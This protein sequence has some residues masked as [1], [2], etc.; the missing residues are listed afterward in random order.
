MTSVLPGVDSCVARYSVLFNFSQPLYGAPFIRHPDPVGDESPGAAGAG[1]MWHVYRMYVGDAVLFSSSLQ[2]RLE[3]GSVQNELT[4]YPPSQAEG[5]YGHTVF[6]Y[7]FPPA[8]APARDRTLRDGDDEADA[9]SPLPQCL[10]DGAWQLQAGDGEWR[11]CCLDGM[12][13]LDTVDVGEG[14][15]EEAH[16][17]AVTT[18]VG[19]VERGALGGVFVFL[20]GVESG[21]EP[22]ETEVPC[23]VGI[24]WK[25]ERRVITDSEGG[26]RRQGWRGGAGESWRG[27]EV[28]VCDDGE[29]LVL[30]ATIMHART[31]VCTHTHARTHTHT[32]THTHECMQACTCVCTHA[33]ARTLALSLS[34][35][36]KHG[37]GDSRPPV[38]ATMHAR[39]LHRG[40][41]DVHQQDVLLPQHMCTRARIGGGPRRRGGDVKRRVAGDDGGRSHWELPTGESSVDRVLAV[42]AE[43]SGAV[44][45]DGGPGGG[46]EDGGVSQ[47]RCLL[48]CGE[49]CGASARV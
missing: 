27:C 33:R 2:G 48:R 19:A 31:P 34:D 13:V 45:W 8:F 24:A 26:A 4:S 12:V 3:H 42:P 7:R 35:A 20:E 14:V 40:F 28:G 25:I 44:W 16:G 23:K 18:T 32:H 1:H 5:L 41:S 43:S 37:T 22:G 46:G 36:H 39:K 15:S 30:Q 17:Y 29:A 47:R 49:L 10:R 6:Y 21:M 11:G 38:P 9:Q